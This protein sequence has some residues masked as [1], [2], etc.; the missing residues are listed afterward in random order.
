MLAVTRI[1]DQGGV[2]TALSRQTPIIKN[3]RLFKSRGFYF[4]LPGMFYLIKTSP[5]LILLPFPSVNTT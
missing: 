2:K 1:N 5:V 3:P 4:G